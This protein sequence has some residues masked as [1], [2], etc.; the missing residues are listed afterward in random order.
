M[1]GNR[2]KKTKPSSHFVPRPIE[3]TRKFDLLN[4]C[5]FLFVI[6]HTLCPVLMI[7]K[8]LDTKQLSKALKQCF[9]SCILNVSDWQTTY[10]SFIYHHICQPQAE[11]LKDITLQ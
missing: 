6:M 2:V 11:F 10:G 1:K 4:V 7:S 8:Q 9:N 5:L 3:G